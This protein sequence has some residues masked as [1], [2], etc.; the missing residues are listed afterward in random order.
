MDRQSSSPGPKRKDTDS[1]VFRLFISFTW[2]NLSYIL[3]GN[4]YSILIDIFTAIGYGAHS[5]LTN[6]L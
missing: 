6:T 5:R 1:I 4:A 2:F 3:L